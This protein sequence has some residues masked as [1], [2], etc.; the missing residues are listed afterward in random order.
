MHDRRG[1]RASQPRKRVWEE[2]EVHRR[3]KVPFWGRTRGGGVGPPKEYISLCTCRLSDA[4]H[5]LC[6]LWVAG[7]NCHSLLRLQRWA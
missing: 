4:G 5:L 7:V 3:R 6:G 1:N 2:A